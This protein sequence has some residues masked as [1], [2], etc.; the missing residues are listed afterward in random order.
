MLRT[1]P[2]RILVVD[3]EAE[4]RRTLKLLLEQ[5][6]YTVRCAANGREALQLLKQE[7]VELLITDLVMPEKEGLELIRELRR[8]APELKIIAMSGDAR[9]MDPDRNLEIAGLLGADASFRKPLVHVAFL[10]GIRKLL[11]GRQKSEGRSQ[12]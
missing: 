1:H 8:S 3:D 4:I 7:I 9:H 10:E 11:G 12:K 2:A 6:G 5:E